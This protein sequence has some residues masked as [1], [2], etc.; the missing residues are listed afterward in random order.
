MKRCPAEMMKELKAIKAELDELSFHNY[1]TTISYYE[2]EGEVAPERHFDYDDIESRYTELRKRELRLR[3][4]MQRFNATT[5]LI[6]MEEYTVSEGL[7]ILGQR[8][9]DLLRLQSLIS[10]YRMDCKK[11]ITKTV[12]ILEGNPSVKRT[13]VVEHLFSI[14]KVKQ[15]I[16]ALQHEVSEIQIAIDRTNMITTIEM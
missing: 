2:G 16:K 4:I 5:P 11:Q 10:S 15:D 12:E 9:N 6:G 7:I 14:A 13:H 3:G 1:E 8:K